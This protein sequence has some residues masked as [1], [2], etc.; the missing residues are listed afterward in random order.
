[1]NVTLGNTEGA[2][3]NGQFREIGNTQGTQEEREKNRIPYFLENW[4][5][6]RFKIIQSNTLKDFYSCKF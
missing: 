1:M 4:M 5:E 3:K 6:S 2:I